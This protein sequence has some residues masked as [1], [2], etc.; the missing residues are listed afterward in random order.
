MVAPLKG[1]DVT[2][3]LT[4]SPFGLVASNPV[5]KISFSDLAKGR[6]PVILMFL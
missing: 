5:E 3:P 6:Q 1:P 4:D 2:A